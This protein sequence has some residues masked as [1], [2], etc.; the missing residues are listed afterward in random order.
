MAREFLSGVIEG[1][2]GKPWSQAERFELLDWLSA[3]GLNTYLYAPKDDLKHRALWRAAYTD[4]E[5]A[6]LRRLIARCRKKNI[7]FIYALAPG[8]DIT[9]SS[10]A[11][12]TALTKKLDDVKELGCEDFA[13]L[14]D[15]I[16][17]A[18]REPDAKKFGSFA[19]AQAAAANKALKSGRS[20]FCPTPY[21]GR[22]ARRNLGGANYLEIIGR[23]LSHDIEVFWTGP[24]IISEEISLCDTRA[25]AELL[26]RKPLIWDNLHA[27][28]YDG[29]RFF[30]GPYCGRPAALRENVAG[31]LIN[32]NCEFPL[33]HN[34]V[35]T[36]ADYLRSDEDWHPRR[37]YKTA[38][39]EWRERF[40]AVALDDLILFGD[41]YYLPHRD[42]L[43]AENL[44]E[45]ARRHVR[46]G[47]PAFEALAARLKDFC[48]RLTALKDRELFYALWRRAWELR[49]ELD[50]LEKFPA[51]SDFH[52]PGTYRGGFVPRLQKLL[53]QNR[54]GSFRA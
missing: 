20:L 2:Y 32:P 51:A 37:A 23:E 53:K 12:V 27:N 3:W 46:G 9:Y 54:D 17:D 38:M 16:P 47:D 6:P 19:A 26:R 28:D 40:D 5:A 34:A 31:I 49:E 43:E 42:G 10:R 30:C 22:M 15:D 13:L 50:L 29:R 48:A 36:L 41:C 45:A 35:R 11:D 39:A 52:L 24:E 8:L 33:N 1:F 18:L 44:F 14:F 7:R 21:C 25:V 4:D